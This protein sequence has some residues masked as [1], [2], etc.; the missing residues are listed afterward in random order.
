[1]YNRFGQFIDGKWQPSS[2]KETYDVINPATEE[3]IGKASKA[4][5]ADVEKAL[6]SINGF[7]D[8]ILMDP[9]YSL[10][11]IHNILNTVSI[12]AKPGAILA[13][14]HSKR[15]RLEDE[16]KGFKL[17]KE[18]RQ[19]DTICSIYREDQLIDNRIIP[20]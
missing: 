7:Y 17:I 20:G 3:V 18:S 12:I 13:T 1:M 14:G 9:P 19:G 2:N 6:K 5:S 4:S 10:G 16:Y 15:H 8:I 11:P